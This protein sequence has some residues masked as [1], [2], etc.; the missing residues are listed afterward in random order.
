MFEYFSGS[1]YGWNQSLMLALEAGGNI[2]EIDAV[3]RPLKE[4]SVSKPRDGVAEE[5]WYAS[6]EGL[7]RHLEELAVNDAEAGHWLTAGR[8]YLRASIYYLIAEKNLSHRDARKLQIYSRAIAVFKKGIQLSKEP[9][10]WVEVPFRGSSLP[11]LFIE[12]PGNGR[13]PCMI[14]FG[15]FDNMKEIY[16]FLHSGQEFRRRGMTL[17][18]VDHPGVG[19]ALRLR[20]MPL[21]PKTEIPAAA[22][23]D[24]LEGR[25]DVDPERIGILGPSLGG[26]YAPR[27]AAFE[28]RLKCCVAWGA[29]WKADADHLGA[30]SGSVSVPSFQLLFV[31]GKDTFEEAKEVVKNMTLDGVAD[32]ITCP[33]LVVHGENDRVVPLWH[34]ERLIEAAVN[35]PGH[36][37]KVFT[38]A[39][40]AAEHCGVDTLTMVADYVADWAAEILGG[41]PKG[42]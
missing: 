1:Y 39:E 42:P 33:L 10:E 14:H 8:K 3:C 13:A 19:E 29:V 28:K 24:Y 25:T 31:T 26:Y 18:I 38:R 20:N 32:K 40:G 17:L 9:V 2:N 27:A 4:M 30:R 22:C 37:L 7:G 16:Y 34:A 41:S 21:E 23:V 35:S 6:W 5:A 11:A 36:K 15:G 12:A